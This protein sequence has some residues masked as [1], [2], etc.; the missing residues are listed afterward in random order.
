MPAVSV[1]VPVFN[2]EPYIARCA[3]SLFGQT[4]EDIEYIFVDDCT[5]DRSMEVLLKVLEDYPERKSQVKLVRT[6]QNG[7]LARARLAGFA[8]ATG[9]YIIH[10]DS[11][12]EV[13]TNAYRQ[14][15][16]KAIAEDLDVVSCDFKL[17][18][19]KTPRVQSQVSEPG[20]EIGDIL[21]GKVWGC[22][23]SRMFKHSLWDG[24]VLPKGGDMW[25]DVVFSVQAICQA[26]RISNIAIPLY[27]YCRCLHASLPA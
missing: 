27:T 17:V 18:G 11:D 16:E 2:V 21:S 25:E 24:M 13:D 22:V 8:K 26:R 6:P 4:L 1:I 10:C 14:M 15:Y 19:I 7:G 9:D 23:W 20:R 5:P 3:R 12:D